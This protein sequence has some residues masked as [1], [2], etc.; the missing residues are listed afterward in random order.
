MN[1]RWKQSAAGVL[2]ATVSPSDHCNPPKASASSIES[3]TKAMSKLFGY[4]PNANARALVASTN[5]IGVLVGDMILSL[6]RSLNRSTTAREEKRQTHLSGQRLVMTVKKRSKPLN[7]W[8][9]TA[10]KIHLW[11]TKRS[12]DE[13]LIGCRQ[14]SERLSVDQTLYRRLAEIAGIFLITRKRGFATEWFD[15]SWP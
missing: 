9:S 14:R 11:F 7:C 6:A 8:S 13:E 2:A 5:T 1:Q 3:V 15:L 12:T 4:R 10:G